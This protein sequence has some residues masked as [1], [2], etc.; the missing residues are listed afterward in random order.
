M[1]APNPTIEREVLKLLEEALEQ[2][3]D[4]RKTWLALKLKEREL[5]G[6]R[7]ED[8]VAFAKRRGL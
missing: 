1:A 8:L 4:K 5:V 7:V 3:E 6:Q 2:P